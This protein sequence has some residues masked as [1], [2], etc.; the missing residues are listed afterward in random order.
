[1][2]ALAQL[3]SYIGGKAVRVVDLAP[4]GAQPQG[5][6]VT[7]A[8]KE[9]IQ[10]AALVIDVGDGYQPQVEAAA[11]RAHRVL[12]V[13][14]GVSKQPRPY[15]FWLD[16]YLMAKGATLIA[17]EL[18]ATDPAAKREFENGSRNFQSV[19]SSIE[20]DFESTFTNCTRNEFVT[21]DGAFQRLATSFDLVDVA[22]DVA[23]VGKAT[24]VVRQYSLPAVFSEVGVPSGLLQQ[25]AQATGATVKTLDPLELAPPPGGPAPLSYFSAMEYDLTALEGP[26][27]CDTTG[28]YF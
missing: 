8:I 6:P 17:R 2:Y 7:A 16:P 20:S 26:L 12:S 13:L 28:N 4:P 18:S 5:L 22:V 24:T 10:H 15:E 19:A 3:A 9:A 11:T 14:P 25:V 27:A 21:S 23:G 1:M